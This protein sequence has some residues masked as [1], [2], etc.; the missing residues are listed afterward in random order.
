MFN[1]IKQLGNTVGSYVAAAPAAP[2]LRETM[3]IS[4][5]PESTKYT[6]HLLDDAFDKQLDAIKPGATL[7]YGVHER[8]PEG[9][10]TLERLTKVLENPTNYAG[11][12]KPGVDP[13]IGI[14]PN[15]DR[16]L[17]AHELGH[18]ASQQTDVGNYVAALRYNPKMQKALMGAMLTV[19]ALAAVLEE[20]D[21]DM[22]TSVA[23]AALSAAPTVV[24]EALATRQGLA[25][26]DRAGMRADLG[27]R[28]KLAGGLLSYLAAPIIAGTAGNAIGNMLD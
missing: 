18:L 22:D 2:A 17:Y 9:K 12:T 1:R 8:V 5:I 3:R 16:A 7:N 24:D 25:I 10:D 27:Q 14:N 11:S 19:P 4:P 6:A 15:A 28:G 13:K 21:D 23:L 20:G 26:M